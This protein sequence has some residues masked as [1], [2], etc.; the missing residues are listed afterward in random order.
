MNTPRQMFVMMLAGWVNEQQRAVNAY[1]R[2]ENRV[3][4]ELHGH[5][6]LRFSDD[7]RRRLAAKGKALGRRVLREAE[8]IVTPA[9]ILHWHRELIARKYDGSALRGPGRPLIRRSVHSLCAWRVRTRAGATRRSSG[10][11]RNWDIG[12]GDQL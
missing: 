7:Q 9:T 8:P 1:L 5:K 2:E 10:N 3:L 11:S 6:R 4:R 12:S